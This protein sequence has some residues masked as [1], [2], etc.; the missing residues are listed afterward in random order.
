MYTGYV[1]SVDGLQNFVINERRSFLDDEK[2]SDPFDNFDV[3]TDLQMNLVDLNDM[4]LADAKRNQET[5]ANVYWWVDIAMVN[6]VPYRV[7]K[8]IAGFGLPNDT[9]FRANFGLFNNILPKAEKSHIYP[10]NGSSDLGTVSSLTM[11]AQ[12]LWIRNIPIV[13]CI[14]EWVEAVSNK[15]LTKKQADSFLDYYRKRFAFFFTTVWS[16]SKYQQY[17]AAY[18]DAEFLAEVIARECET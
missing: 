13:A 18:S 1:E 7:D 2:A 4:I 15:V 16:S 17:A 3:E 9:K 8:Y 10:G 11:F 14:P 5:K 6:V 12:T